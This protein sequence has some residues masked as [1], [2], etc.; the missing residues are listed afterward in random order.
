M[1]VHSGWSN[2]FTGYF[3]KAVE[4]IPPIPPCLLFSILIIHTP[5]CLHLHTL[6]FFLPPSCVIL[7][8]P[9]SFLRAPSCWLLPPSSFLKKAK[10]ASGERWKP[11]LGAKA[12]GQAGSHRNHPK[13]RGRDYTIPGAGAKVKAKLRAKLE[14]RAGS[15]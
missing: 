12:E 13:L 6:S 5:R 3:L 2:I 15:L 4:N 7:L 11:K 14:V 8:P 1:R 10:E 9:C